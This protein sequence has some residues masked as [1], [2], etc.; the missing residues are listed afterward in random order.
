MFCET[1]KFLTIFPDSA[2]VA[3]TLG[4]YYQY[5]MLQ[6][7]PTNAVNAQ[8]VMYVQLHQNS[9]FFFFHLLMCAI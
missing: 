6:S 7:D 3:S 9:L 1:L 2:I 4:V 5:T 8:L